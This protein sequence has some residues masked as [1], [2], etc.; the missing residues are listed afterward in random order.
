MS[1]FRLLGM[2]K[3]KAREDSPERRTMAS[4]LAFASMMMDAGISGPYHQLQ[5]DLREFSN[6]CLVL[7]YRFDEKNKMGPHLFIVM[8]V[9]NDEVWDHFRFS[10]SGSF[11][12]LAGVFDAGQN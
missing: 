12:T 7:R 2:F 11:G 1:L 8:D 3:M 5:A 4:E 10:E 9:P 6:G